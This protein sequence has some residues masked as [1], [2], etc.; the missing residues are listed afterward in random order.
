MEA[1]EIARKVKIVR[2]LSDTHDVS[3]SQSLLQSYKT[4]IA[5]VVE[6]LPHMHNAPGSIPSTT[7]IIL[8]RH[9]S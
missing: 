7:K 3:G 5:Q 1:G 6:C 8:K 4:Q 9:N 2:Y